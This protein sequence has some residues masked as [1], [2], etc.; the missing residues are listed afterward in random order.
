MVC[1]S[2]KDHVATAYAK[3]FPLYFPLD[4]GVKSSTAFPEYSFPYTTTPLLASPQGRAVA[5]ALQE[6]KRINIAMGQD[7]EK[8]RE[9]SCCAPTREAHVQASEGTFREGSTARRS[10]QAG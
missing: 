5:P 8:T 1:F 6:K 3:N 2:H 10:V 4:K 9:I 7:G